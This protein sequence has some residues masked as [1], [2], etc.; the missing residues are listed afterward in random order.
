MAEM[1][2]NYSYCMLCDFLA[3]NFPNVQ[4]LFIIANQITLQLMPWLDKMYTFLTLTVIRLLDKIT[5]TDC[6]R[7]YQ[8]YFYYIRGKKQNNPL[9]EDHTAFY[10]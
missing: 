4:F 10:S 5:F 9:T 6:P 2:M 7:F 3:M 1:P 8:S